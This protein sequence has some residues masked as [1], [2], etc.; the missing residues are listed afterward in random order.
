VEPESVNAVSNRARQLGR[1]IGIA[2]FSLLVATFTVVCS[3][4]ICLQVWAPE[5][6]PFTDGPSA[7]G[8]LST[9][10]SAGTLRL[11]EAIEAA[12]VASAD[13]A[14]EQAALALFRGALA[15]EWTHRGAIDRACAGD[16]NAIQRLRAV[17]RLRYAEEHA[18]RYGA[19][20]LAKRRQEVK[21]LIPL[22]RKS[23]D[24]AL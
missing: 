4:Q 19:I 10:C 14:E 24:R 15:P 11:A 16:A 9:D 18:V 23:V 22:L 6:T 17:D 20:D 7:G 5:V 3:V 21:R 2:V 1:T 13:E 12:R 8:S